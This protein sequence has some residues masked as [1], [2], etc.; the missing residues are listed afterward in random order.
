MFKNQASILL[1]A[2]ALL[3]LPGA[4]AAQPGKDKSAGVTTT[5]AGK[6]AVTM[7]GLMQRYEAL[8][9]SADNAK[10]LVYGL[11]VK[12]EVVLVGEG[13]PCSGRFCKSGAVTVKFVPKTDPMGLGNIDIALA[14]TEADLEAKSVKANPKELEAALQGGTVGGVTLEGILKMRADGMG[15]GEIANLLGFKLK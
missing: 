8:A 6:G 7:E 2:S 10:S 9:G 1:I 3:M 4:A 5:A 12:D 11:R 13:T 14:L 15:W